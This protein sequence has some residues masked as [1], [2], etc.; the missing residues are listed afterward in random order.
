MIQKLRNTKGFTLIE[1]MIVIMIIGIIAIIAVPNIVGYL[2]RDKYAP[3]QIEV[4][5]QEEEA[6]MN[7]TKPL[8]K[9]TEEGDKKK[10]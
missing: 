10:L 7:K 8:E 1:L 3:K 2:N 5:T 9:E 4:M 6:Q